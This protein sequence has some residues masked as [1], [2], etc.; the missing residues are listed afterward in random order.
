MLVFI[1]PKPTNTMDINSRIKKDASELVFR[2]LKIPRKKVLERLEKSPPGIDSDIALPCFI[3]AKEMKKKPQELAREI[4]EKAK[5][6][7][8]VKE[9]RVIG[10]YV[11]FYADWEKL[12]QLIL[13]NVLKEGESYGSGKPTKKKILLEHTS[14]NPDGPLH[15]GHFRNSVIGDSLSKILS[16]SGNRVKTEYF[17]NNTGRQIGIAALEYLDTKTR[18]DK[19][20]D[21]WVVELYI[22]GNK[23]LEDEDFNNR[24]ESIIQR[25]EGGDQSIAR[26]YNLIV[27]NCI[28]GHK[29]TLARLNIKIDSFVKESRFLFGGDVDS[30][31]RKLKKTRYFK[32]KGKRYWL[33][34][35][36]F[37]IER[38]FTLTR[39]NGTTIYPLRD[40][41][42]H[43]YKF[44]QADVNINVIGTDQ[45]F[46][47]KQLN[48]A[49]GLIFPKA[50]KNYHMVFYEFLIIPEGS[51]S[52][53]RGKFLSVDDLLDQAI[54]A[55]RRIVKE[56]MP[57]YKKAI[58]EEVARAVGIGALK[59]AMV[60]VSPEKTYKF[61]LRETLR[62]DGNTAP[63]VQ[64]THARACSILGKSNIGVSK[65][66]AGLLKDL[67]E[68]II[69]E[70]LRDFPDVVKKSSDALRPHLISNYVY[71][72]STMFN[73]F[74]QALPVL[75]AEPE[76]RKARLALVNAVKIVIKTS[77]GLLGIEA[78]ERM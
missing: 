19:K 2:A 3:L 8:L 35:K 53:R 57:E 66:N 41:A 26:A 46:Y 76:L 50:M 20:P 45:K 63:Y 30:V 4:G 36:K 24:L 6:Y 9:T 40:L 16:F 47:F 64:Y 59:Y 38:E 52:T 15:L 12:S 74:Y 68:R 58:K 23:R 17:V 11:N 28:K 60:K 1:N 39:E 56:K 65:F 22:N 33:N 67:K 7:G 43:K 14:A 55:A 29:E 78:P 69:L 31:I 75:K 42:Y 77:L 5:A 44:S 48:A 10:P 37:G 49:L 21:W 18:P 62:F 73:E 71:D 13:D 25:Y 70:A 34:L 51:M 61:D 27:D 54:D 32:F 72:L